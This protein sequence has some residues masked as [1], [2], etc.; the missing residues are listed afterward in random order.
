M[1]N[2]TAQRVARELAAVC[3]V[4][5]VVLG[6]SHCTG[7]ATEQ[8]DLDIGVYYNGSLDTASMDAAIT[9]LDDA[10][11]KKLLNVPG[12]WGNWINGGAWLTVGGMKVDILL[13]DVA[14]VR[15]VIDDCQQ[16]KVTMD[17]QCGHPF[18]F[19]SAIYMGEVKYCLPLYDPYQAMEQLKKLADPVSSA[20]RSS[21]S[22]W[23]LWEAGFSLQT[24][25]ASSVKHDIVY[26]AGAL[27]KGVMCLVQALFATNGEI[28]LNE[29]GALRRLS[30][31]TFC[32]A[33][34]VEDAEAALQGLDKDHLGRSFELLEKKN[35]QVSRLLESDRCV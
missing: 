29:K 21:V 15:Q 13:R 6:G 33:S 14:K 35:L 31:S 3:G 19:C 11:R 8:S 23:F 9:R 32:P 4:Q 18:G 30:Q 17:F 24:G 5:A 1:G 10:G 27:F 25:K 22:G 26:A 28:L 2:E 16:G 34:F 12:Q 20:Y 7:T